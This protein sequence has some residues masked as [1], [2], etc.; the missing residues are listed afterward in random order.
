METYEEQTKNVLKSYSKALSSKIRRKKDFTIYYKNGGDTISIFT[1]IKNND[2]D[3]LVNKIYDSEAE[4]LNDF[5]IQDAN[6]N[7]NINF[8]VIPKYSYPISR[9]VPSNFKRYVKAQ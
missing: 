1:I 6:A 7:L 3:S 8:R 4:I 2:D 5:V 9:L